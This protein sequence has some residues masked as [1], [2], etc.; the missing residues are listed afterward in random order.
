MN[1]LG[2]QSSSKNRWSELK[3][4]GIGSCNK[5]N[6][7]LKVNLDDLSKHFGTICNRPN[8]NPNFNLNRTNAGHSSFDSSVNGMD[9]EKFFIKKMKMMDIEKALRLSTSKSSGPDDL[10]FS[11]YRSSDTTSI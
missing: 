6:N 4:L 3:L 1:R 5:V 11:C 8:H 7:E 9:V 2:N 10:A